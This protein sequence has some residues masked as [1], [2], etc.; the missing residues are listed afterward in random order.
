MHHITRASLLDSFYDLSL[1]HTHTQHTHAHRG[2]KVQISMLLD[3][4]KNPCTCTRARLWRGGTT[5]DKIKKMK[6]GVIKQKVK[7]YAANPAAE[8]EHH[9]SPDNHLLPK[10]VRS[11]T[12]KNRYDNTHAAVIPAHCHFDKS[13]LGQAHYH[14]IGHVRGVCSFVPDLPTL[15]QQYVDGSLWVTGE[16]YRTHLALS[17]SWTFSY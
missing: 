7:N 13:W 12:R 17:A 9:N 3:I 10:Q 8:K 14:R 11:S 6:R 5:V 2:W 4:Q 1:A 15:V 16:R